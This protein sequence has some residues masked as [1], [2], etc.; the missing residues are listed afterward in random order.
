M[1]ALR[2]W[3]NLSVLSGRLLPTNL[4]GTGEQYSLLFTQQFHKANGLKAILQLFEKDYL[5]PDT[6]REM[7]Q[8][9]YI[10]ALQ[11]TRFLLCGQP[12]NVA[13][14]STPSTMSYG[15]ALTSSPMMK[16][17]PPKKTALDASVQSPL[18][19]SATRA[20]QTMSE[21]QFLEMVTMLMGLAWSSSVG[22]FQ[23]LATS[24]DKSVDHVGEK[25]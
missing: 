20:V 25:A 16:P 5:P 12:E 9:I 21:E 23:F 14:P 10:L 1:S 3:Y 2:V 13:I 22:D 7:R 6:E 4:M 8:S 19:M 18:A 11:V 24:R 15:R 17:T